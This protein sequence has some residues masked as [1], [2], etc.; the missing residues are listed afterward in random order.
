[1]CVAG[2]VVAACAA[3]APRVVKPAAAIMTVAVRPRRIVTP[4]ELPVFIGNFLPG[5]MRGEVNYGPCY[6]G[7][8]AQGGWTG[9]LAVVSSIN[10]VGSVVGK[11]AMTC[12]MM[13]V[14]Q[15]R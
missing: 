5:E 4:R 15:L 9:S 6:R 3:V 7:A 1:M 14:L 11:R 2:M 10:P 13:S 12:L 8:S